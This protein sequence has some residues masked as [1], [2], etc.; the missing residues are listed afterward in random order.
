MNLIEP[1]PI[2]SI[3]KDIKHVS[4]AAFLAAAPMEQEASGD[5]HTQQATATRATQNFGLSQQEDTC[6]LLSWKLNV[7]GHCS[8][9][10]WLT[11]D[12]NVAQQKDV[13]AHPSGHLVSWNCGYAICSPQCQFKRSHAILAGCLTLVGFLGQ[14]F[15]DSAHLFPSEV[16]R[17]R[18][19]S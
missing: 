18:G 5:A 14:F 11:G 16:R 3:P 15:L 19:P 4:W 2:T 13:T 17:F 12:G 10:R 8:D 9:L 7:R 1:E 6:P